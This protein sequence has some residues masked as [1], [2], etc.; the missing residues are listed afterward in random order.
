[1][2]AII[3]INSHIFFRLSSVFSQPDC[4]FDLTTQ[5]ILNR[6]ESLFLVGC[7]KH[8]VKCEVKKN[9]KKKLFSSVL[10]LSGENRAVLLLLYRIIVN[11]KAAHLRFTLKTELSHRTE[12]LT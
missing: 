9:E 3:T 7:L 4:K 2:L 6:G 11:T 8:K 10:L 12:D 1:M 5:N